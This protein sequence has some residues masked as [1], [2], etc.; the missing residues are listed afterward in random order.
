MRE[1]APRSSLAS[2]GGGLGAIGEKA[3]QWLVKLLPGVAL[4][5]FWQWASGRLIKEIYVSKP[6]AVVARLY[7]LFSSGEIYPHLW[8][9]GQE[10]VLG[11]VIGVAGGVLAGYS[12]G[13]SSRLARIF[14][15]YV[16][17]FYGIPKIALAPLFIIWFGIGIGSKVALASIMVFFLVFYNVFAGV[18]SVDREL[19]N[20]TLIM[21]ANQRQLTY[22]VFL[23]AAAPFVM[24]GMRLAIPYSVIGVI[25]GE[26]TSS[27][28]G[29]GLFIH[30]A[31]STYDPAGVFAG[32]VILLGFVTV[33][34]LIAGAIERRLLRWRTLSGSGPIDA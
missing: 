13:R 33:A 28:Q 16:M 11:Y 1:V 27:V 14:E 32:I 9:T 8:I 19:V 22:H 7:E 6:T 24:L 4:L 26:F 21:G 12:L 29:L 31:S 34:N 3:L 20:L 18:R 25:V 23:P 2:A 17:A 30:E 5:I 15:P 10:L